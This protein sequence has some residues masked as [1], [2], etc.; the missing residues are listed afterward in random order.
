MG[1][2]SLVM[3]L[4]NQLYLKNEQMECWC[5]FRKVKSYFNYFLVSVVKNGNSPQTHETLK[6]AVS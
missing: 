6:S 1:V 5:K 3:E 2:T 4:Y